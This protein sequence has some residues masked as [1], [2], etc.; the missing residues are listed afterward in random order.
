MIKIKLSGIQ[1][2]LLVHELEEKRKEYTL[3]TKSKLLTP[4]VKEQAR[5]RAN[6]LGDII[7]IVDKPIDE[8]KL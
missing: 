7:Q 1:A 5:L 2:Q 3:A 6:R 4:E 8:G